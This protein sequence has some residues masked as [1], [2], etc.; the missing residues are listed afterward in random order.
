MTLKQALASLP[1]IALAFAACGGDK[2]FPPPKAAQVEKAPPAQTTTTTSAEAVKPNPNSAVNLSD[3][4]RKACGIVDNTDRSPK[5]DFDSSDLS[6]AEKDLLSQLA[7][8][9]TEGPLKGRSIQLV[10]RADPRGE[11][12]YNMELGERRADQVKK[13]LSGLG[14]EAGRVG[15]TSRGELDATGKDDEGWRKDRRVD[16]NLAK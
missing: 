7:K 3:E 12:E 14:V 15:E 6:P 11:Q 5:F 16:I 8:C 1:L 13:Y 10:G 9:L 4:I 2:K